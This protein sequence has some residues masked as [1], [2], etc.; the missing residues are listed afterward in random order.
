MHGGIFGSSPCRWRMAGHRRSAAKSLDREGGRDER[1]RAS[2]NT[3][4]R[5]SRV[6]MAVP[7]IAAIWLCMTNDLSSGGND[8]EEGRTVQRHKAALQAHAADRDESVQQ[9]R[10]IGRVL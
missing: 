10:D 3:G 7:D 6:V 8:V 9:E 2:R 4:P 1:G 5:G